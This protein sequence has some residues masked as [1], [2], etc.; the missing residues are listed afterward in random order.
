VSVGAASI[1]IVF[2]FEPKAIQKVTPRMLKF[3]ILG[4]YR[5]DQLRHPPPKSAAP[6]ARP[7]RHTRRSR[8]LRQSDIAGH[9][10]VGGG[11]TV[12]FPPPSPYPRERDRTEKCWS[13]GDFPAATTT[14][15]AAAPLSLLCAPAW[16][17]S[18]RA[19]GAKRTGRGGARRAV[20]CRSVCSFVSSVTWRFYF[21]SQHE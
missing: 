8:S 13:S 10:G 5:N 4:Q 17:C 15:V 2:F 12:S 19:G 21:F 3:R 16:T 9:G 7:C 1:E 11:R 6:G 18:R 20:V 14:S